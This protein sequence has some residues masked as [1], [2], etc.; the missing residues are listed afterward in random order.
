MVFTQMTT[1]HYDIYFRGEI[2][3]GQDLATVKLNLANV[4]QADEKKI[5]ALFSGKT[6]LLKKGLD[7]QSALKYQTIL[8]KAGAKII[9]KTAQQTPTE[10]S[11]AQSTQ[12]SAP[13]SES[14]R[15]NAPQPAPA[16]TASSTAATPST[17]K[18]QTNQ[19]AES[20]NNSLN[21]APPGA[22][23]L[24]PSER[25]SITPV[26][27]DTSDIQLAS[28]FQEI[29]NDAPPASPPPDTSHISV[30]EVG[31]DLQDEE[32]LE[33]ELPF[34]DISHL[35]ID[36][37]GVRLSAEQKD[38]SLPELDLSQLSLAPVGERLSS[39]DKTPEPPAP[40]T[41]HLQIESND[42]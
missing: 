35:D 8:K 25:K 7:K 41:S 40:D 1:A 34:P 3:D 26:E 13:V 22:D 15:N 12:P 32:P 10:N 21:L 39:A 5:A 17:A 23:L 29:T 27:I 28:V 33:L 38:I 30:A 14:A 16:T 2:A 18:T 9:I 20:D 11:T 37:V 36:E 4:F 19:Q 42:T 6:C 24:K 31:A